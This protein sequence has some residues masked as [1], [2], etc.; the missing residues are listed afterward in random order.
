[1]KFHIA[2]M[3]CSGCVQTVT[4][5]IQALDSSA[6]VT[7]DIASRTVEVTTSSP[8]SEIEAALSNVNYQAHYIA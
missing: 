6:I 8:R 7:A 4:R 2:K 1:M 5:A 3:T